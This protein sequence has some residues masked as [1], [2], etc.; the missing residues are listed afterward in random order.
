MTRLRLEMW[1]GRVGNLDMFTF[2]ITIFGLHVC[3][4]V[5]YLP[6]AADQSVLIW[7]L[8]TCFNTGFAGDWLENRMKPDSTEIFEPSS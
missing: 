5:T 8:V 3:S 1:S 2:L 4:T 7:E 6:S